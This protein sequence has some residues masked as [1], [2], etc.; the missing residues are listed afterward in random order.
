MMAGVLATEMGARGLTETAL[1]RT[2][3]PYQRLL[4]T[5]TREALDFA[6]TRLKGEGER[7]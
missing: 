5:W 4:K 6:S 2:V 1:T 7:E 3:E